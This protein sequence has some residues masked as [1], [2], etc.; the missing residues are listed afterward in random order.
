MDEEDALAC[1]KV[2][3]PDENKP[4]EPPWSE[5]S[6]IDHVRAVRGC[7]DHD[8]VESFQAVQFRE[9]LTDNSFRDLGIRTCPS[10]GSNGIELVKEYDGRGSLLCLPEGLAHRLLA[11][12][13][14]FAQKLGTLHRDEVGLALRGNGLRQEGLPSPGRTV[15]QDPLWGFRP[16]VGEQGFVLHGPF[17][18]LPE[19]LLLC[20]KAADVLPPDV[21]GLDEHLAHGG[22]FHLPESVEEIRSCDREL[23]QYLGGNGLVVIVYF[24]E[25]PSQ[26]SHGGFLGEGCHIRT[27]IT[28]GEVRDLLDVH[29]LLKGHP[30]GVDLHDD[31][32]SLSVRYPDLDLPVQP[33]GSSQG[34]IKGIGTVRCPDDDD[35]SAG[36]QPFHEGEKLGH[37]AL[38]H[39]SL[40]LVTLGCDGIDLVDEDDGWGVLLGLLED[41]PE[42]LLA[43]TVELGHDLGTAEDVEVGFRLRCHCL[44]KK[45][46]PCPGRSEEQDALGSLHPELLEDLGMPER[47]LDHLPHLPDLLLEP[48]DVLVG[49]PGH[50]LD[51]LGF[52]LEHD[53]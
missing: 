31:Q 12:A 20:L 13:H 44:G 9:E 25:D 28:V 14:P 8:V 1:L 37:H 50:G 16:E 6:G 42:V 45:G 33:S 17:N 21:R 18:H 34:G 7:D 27:G 53:G 48:A 30:P 4:V 29:V 38:L 41:G 43:L 11:L 32:P 19:L 24:R 51:L 46:L 39:L 40:H 52:L 49:H 35:L 2:G 26:G 5:E 47:E 36:F 15:E 3:I 23:V 22:G 10:Q